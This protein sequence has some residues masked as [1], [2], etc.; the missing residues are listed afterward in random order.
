MSNYN[1]LNEF[2]RKHF[3]K[4]FPK[5]TLSKWRKE[6]RIKSQ[7]IPKEER[8][9][10]E[11][12]NYDLESFKEIILSDE[13]IK[14]V[15]ARKEKPED[16][17]NKQSGDLLILGIVPKEERIDK[18]Y[19]G[20]IMYCKCLK[21]NRPDLIQVRFSYLTP[22]GNY[23]QT[24]CGC[25]RK[26]KAFIATSNRKDIS[27]DFLKQF[28]DFEKFLFLHKIIMAN[29][30]RYYINC[31]IKEYQQLIL[32]FYFDNN[33]NKIYKF[34][35]DH[36]EEN[37]TFY[38]LAKPSLD[39]II[40][41]SRG[42]DNDLKNLQFLTVFENLAKRDMTQEEWIEF[43]EKTKTTSDYFIENIVI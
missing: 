8:K 7:E 30:D 16:Y 3:D 5:S 31:D 22:N 23:Q 36:K 19:N 42:G 15:H 10:A 27:E 24:T 11:L 2:Y 18:N 41:K 29:T 14:R 6:G 1:E 12:Y 21:C 25:G 39:H 34:W 38:D 32:H 43:K 9:G 4:D 13:Y 33:F 28:K 17:I 26:E 35:N 40:P 20:T 37:K